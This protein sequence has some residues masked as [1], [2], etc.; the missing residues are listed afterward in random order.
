MATQQELKDKIAEVKSDVAVL[1]GE[2][3][4]LVSEMTAA[5][6]RFL[7]KLAAGSDAQPQIDELNLIQQEVT[8]LKTQ[9]AD[10][11]NQAKI[12]GV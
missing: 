6:S 9:V 12:E 5:F 10:A 2:V 7:A 4:S 8:E 1:K 3:A 11:T